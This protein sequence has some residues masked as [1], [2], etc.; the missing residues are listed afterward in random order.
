MIP[1][2]C[3]KKTLSV[4]RTINHMLSY[5]YTITIVW[6]IF[7]FLNVATKYVLC[8]IQCCYTGQG[9]I[10]CSCI[11]H[12]VDGYSSSCTYSQYTSTEHI[13]QLAKK[14]DEPTHT[15]THMYSVL[16]Y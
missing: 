5:Y 9:R 14:K 15:H 4:E 13:T 3:P 1:A 12:F 11:V 6:L 16:E 8:I 10:R 2:K 7:F